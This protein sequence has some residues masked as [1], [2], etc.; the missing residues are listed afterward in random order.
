MFYILMY[1]KCK[2]QMNVQE[3]FLSSNDENS[4]AA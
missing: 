4:C 1:L 2:K 3:K